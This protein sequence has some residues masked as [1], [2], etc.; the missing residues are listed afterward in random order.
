M[1]GQFKK[2]FFWSNFCILA[3]TLLSSCTQ[4][5]S[6][7]Q[8]TIIHPSAPVVDLDLP[9][10]TIAILGT[11]HFV[12]NVDPYKRKFDIDPEAPETQQELA[13]L[14]A[15]LKQYHPTK[16]LV[17]YPVISQDYLDSLYQAYRQGKYTL[18]HYESMQIGFRLAAE[19]DHEHIYAVDA[20]S[21]LD[22]E[23]EIDDWEGYAYQTGKGP[24][25]KDINDRFDH[26]YYEMDSLK[27][28]MSLPE[29]YAYLNSDS[30]ILAND[31]QKLSGWIEIGAGDTYLGA[32]LVT[33]DYRRN[34]RI[35]ANILALPRT[36]NDRLLLIIGSSHTRI[37]RHLFEDGPEFNYVPVEEYLQ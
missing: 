36:P 15:Q 17:E 37:L 31:Q 25:L 19:L 10:S 26:F 5:D 1:N 2:H 11:F 3:F 8:K 35:Y 16:I 33:K 29:Y 12:A 28:T 32:D 23:V 30:I 22:L 21:P 20:Q 7:S 34:F 14:R 27:T 18:S 4:S 24:K 13:Q 9:V 6:N